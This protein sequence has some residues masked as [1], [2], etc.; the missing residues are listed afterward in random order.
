M[1]SSMHRWVRS[2][3]D[4]LPWLYQQIK[5][6]I[7][8]LII[9]QNTW[10]LKVTVCLRLI[11]KNKMHSYFLNFLQFLMMEHRKQCTSRTEASLCILTTWFLCHFCWMQINIF[12]LFIAWVESAH[13]LLFYV[14]QIEKLKNKQNVFLNGRYHTVVVVDFLRMV[15]CGFGAVGGGTVAGVGGGKLLL[16]LIPSPP[17]SNGKVGRWGGGGS[18]GPWWGIFPGGWTGSL[19]KWTSLFFML[20]RVSQSGQ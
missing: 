8:A 11:T 3:W 10:N 17:F 19:C 2:E 6:G 13:Y 18:R 20:Y 9:N 7:P 5:I 14:Y 4:E 15:F 12:G 16:W 1:T